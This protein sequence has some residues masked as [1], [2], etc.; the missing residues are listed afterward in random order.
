MRNPIYRITHEQFAPLAE[1]L[2][3]HC[4]EHRY[5]YRIVNDVVQQFC[6]LWLGRE[7][8]IR[9][10]LSSVYEKNERKSEGFEL[11][12]LIDGTNNWIVPSSKEIS[13]RVF[14]ADPMLLTLTE[15]SYRYVADRCTDALRSSL[16]PWFSANTDSEN[17]LSAMRRVRD[18]HEGVPEFKDLGFLLAMKEWAQV[19]TILKAYFVDC[20]IPCREAWM[21]EM[22]QEYLPL[23]DALVKG[24]LN[25]VQTYMD[26]KKQDTYREFK[27][28]QD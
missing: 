28:K 11:S 21:K 3:F 18:I 22:Q 17:S 15:E 13:P 8:T 20:T 24:D 5:Y 14:A 27:W 1:P 25:A 12:R 9:F 26:A 19:K 4:I 2:G 16:L 6:L 10:S 7:C 23:Y